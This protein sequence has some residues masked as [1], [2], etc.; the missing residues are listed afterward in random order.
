VVRGFVRGRFPVIILAGREGAQEVGSGGK[1]REALVSGLCMEARAIR[2][3]VCALAIGSEDAAAKSTSSQ[4]RYGNALSSDLLK[5]TAS[6]LSSVPS[7]VI[8]EARSELWITK[9]AYRDY[10]MTI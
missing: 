5:L 6:N 8:H 7:F 1:E 9:E 2:S 4:F 3:H 10:I